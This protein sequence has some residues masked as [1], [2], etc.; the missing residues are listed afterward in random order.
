MKA[1]A[2]NARNSDN[3]FARFIACCLQCILQ[4]IEDIIEYL[5]SYA[6]THVAVYGEDYCTAVR[7]TL[8]LFSNTG[9]DAIINDDLIDSILSMGCI[10]SDLLGGGAGFGVAVLYQNDHKD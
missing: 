1:M 9:W 2:R 7:S 3:G 8:A 10:A 4:C 6:F 5:N